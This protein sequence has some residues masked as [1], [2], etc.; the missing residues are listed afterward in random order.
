MDGCRAN[1]QRFYF[2]KATTMLSV[3]E[4]RLAS[5][6]LD[7]GYPSHDAVRERVEE[8]ASEWPAVSRNF[9]PAD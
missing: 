9:D 7:F 8:L 4:Q 2:D 1:A 5:G 6:D 3:V